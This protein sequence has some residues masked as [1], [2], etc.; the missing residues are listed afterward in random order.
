MRR[1]D[2]HAGKTGLFSSVR[3]GG[4]AGDHLGDL[5]FIHRLRLG[6]QFAVLAHGQRDGGGRPRVAAHVRHHLPARVVKLHPHLRAALA[7]GLGP[8][9]ERGERRVLFQHHAAGAGHGAAV[10][11]HVAGDD[12]AGAA[13]GPIA[14]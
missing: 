5:R 11:H 6:E 9:F 14:V 10:N 7:R 13:F 3:A 8:G 2:L 1:V 4:E 12:Q